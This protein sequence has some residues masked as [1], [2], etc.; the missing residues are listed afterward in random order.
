MYT[1]EQKKQ[2]LY[3]LSKGITVPD[4]VIAQGIVLNNHSILY[5]MLMKNGEEFHAFKDSRDGGLY[6][7]DPWDWL[8]LGGTEILAFERGIEAVELPEN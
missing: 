6:Y 2:L 3:Y 7:I 4:A 8:W 5:R 1:E